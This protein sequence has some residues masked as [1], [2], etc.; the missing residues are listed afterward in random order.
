MNLVSFTEFVEILTTGPFLVLTLANTKGSIIKWEISLV[1]L[2][3]E[4][5]V[6]TVLVTNLNTR[7]S[8]VLEK[9]MDHMYS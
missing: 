9:C 4:A 5:Q 3:N 2:I 7:K 8:Q 1:G 6:N